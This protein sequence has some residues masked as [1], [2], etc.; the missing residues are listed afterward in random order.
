MNMNMNM[1][2]MN[3]N[4]MPNQF[5]NNNMNNQ[6]IM[7]QMNPNIINMNQMYQNFNQINPNMINMNQNVNNI[8]INQENEAEDILPYI[9]EPTKNDIKIFDCVFDKKWNIYSS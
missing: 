2:Q 4:M 6:F 8:N 7:N 5:L 9:N 1:D 3:P